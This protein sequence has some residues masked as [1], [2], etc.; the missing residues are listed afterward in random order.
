[1]NKTKWYADRKTSLSVL[2]ATCSDLAIPSCRSSCRNPNCWSYW[3]IRSRNY[4]PVSCLRQN[5]LR[6]KHVAGKKINPIKLSCSRQLIK[7]GSR[8]QAQNSVFFF[9]FMLQA[10]KPCSKTPTQISIF[11]QLKF[12]VKNKTSNKYLGK[13]CFSVT[14]INFFFLKS[15]KNALFSIIHQLIDSSF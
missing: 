15:N 11:L 8:R 14:N 13:W 4:Q 7:L 5:R 2:M 1:M 3:K 10:K 12:A 9:N 6:H